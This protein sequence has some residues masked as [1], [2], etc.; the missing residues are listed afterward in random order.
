[1]ESREP[2]GDEPKLWVV[3]AGEQ[4]AEVRSYIGCDFWPTVVGNCVW[5]V[6]DYAV[7]VANAPGSDP[8]CGFV[9]DDWASPD[10]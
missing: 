7:V 3:E 4:A 8:T 9:L 2:P 1:M 10:P 6:F 5:S